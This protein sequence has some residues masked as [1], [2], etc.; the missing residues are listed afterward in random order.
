MID[1]REQRVLIVGASSGIGRSLGRQC[2]GAGARVA[3][4]ARRSELVTEAA[5]E[6]GAQCLGL[7]GD[8]RDPGDCERFV[9]EAAI[10]FGGLDA[11]VYAAGI[12]PLTRFGDAGPEIWRTVFETNVL[13]A[14]MVSRAAIPHLSAS[15]G[16]LVLLGSSS[17]GRPYPGLVPYTTSKACLHEMARGLRNEYPELRVT[18][19]VVGPTITGF[20]DS[21]NAELSAAMLT[22]WSLEGYPAG[23]AMTADDTAVQIL[24]VLASGAR[25]DEIHVMPDPESD[26]RL[27]QPLTIRASNCA[28]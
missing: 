20:A 14:A 12:S 5:A 1:L 2:A 3:F 27:N 24:N 26:A 18:T 21:W 7:S 10:M 22:R 6:G 17:V 16:R 19:F 28:Q 25:I 4:A 8:V 11:V 15:N 9:E 13:G 23:S